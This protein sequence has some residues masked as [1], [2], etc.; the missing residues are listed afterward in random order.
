M[1]VSAELVDDDPRDPA[2]R[3]ERHRHRDRR[4]RAGAAVRALHAGRH[5][6]HPALRR[7]RPRAGDLGSARRDDGR[8]ADGRLAPRPWQHLPLLGAARPGTTGTRASRRSRVALPENLRVLVVDDNATNRDIVSAYL[9]GRVTVCDQADERAGRARDARGGRARRPAVRGGRPRQPDAR[10][11]RSRR[12]RGRFAPARSC[13]ACRVVMLTST[14]DQ[15]GSS[16]R[17]R[18]RPVP[19]QARAAGAAAGGRRGGLRER[20]R[21]ARR[22]PSGA[23]GR[24]RG[25]GRAGC[26]RPGDARPRARGRRQRREPAS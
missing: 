25:A 8:R 26:S 11:E 10:H 3:G 16:R 6:D 5:V 24:R 14:G 19:H 7:H 15:W 13:A 9:S 4:G 18:R 20:A 1:R 23:A 21:R 17:S 2:R 22:R 12:G